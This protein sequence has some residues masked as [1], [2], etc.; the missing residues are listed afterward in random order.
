[1]ETA[2]DAGGD[3]LKFLQV[4]NWG[5]LAIC[6]VSALS[7]FAV[8]MMMWAYPQQVA[9]AGAELQPVYVRTVT[10]GLLSLMAGGAIWLLR[11]EHAWQWH[12]QAV[13]AV[14]VVSALA[15]LVLF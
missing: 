11:R 9:Q 1:M 15:G 10:F 6:A 8:C 3:V 4:C 5:V 7:W 12:G 13:L 2:H 14:A